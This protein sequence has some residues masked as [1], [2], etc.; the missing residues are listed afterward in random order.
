MKGLAQAFANFNKVLKFENMD[1]NTKKFSLIKSNVHDIVCL[2]ANLL[3]NRCG[4]ISEK[5]DTSRG[6]SGKSFRRCCQR[7]HCYQMTAPC[8]S[9][10]ADLPVG[11]DVE[12]E[13]SALDDPDPM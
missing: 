10:P 2:Q 3:S 12:V 9:A 8:G 1:P 4:H 5:S 7:R 11:Q 6:A 13:D